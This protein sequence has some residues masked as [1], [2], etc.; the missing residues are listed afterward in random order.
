MDWN[1][2]LVASKELFAAEKF[3]KLLASIIQFNF[4]RLSQVEVNLSFSSSPTDDGRS[5]LEN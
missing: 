1:D 3:S 4:L 2:F 5:L